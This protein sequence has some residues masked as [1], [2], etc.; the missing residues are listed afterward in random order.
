MRFLQE[1]IAKKRAQQAL[2]QA[3]EAGD[4]GEALRPGAAVDGPRADGGAGAP[5]PVG[6]ADWAMAD[7][8][9]AAADEDLFDDEAG[10]DWDMEAEELRAVA[11][12]TEAVGAGE[13]DEEEDYEAGDFGMAEDAAAGH[14]MDGDADED[15]D[16]DAMADDAMADD[17]MDDD[18]ED[19]TSQ[20]LRDIVERSRPEA[21]AW[22]AADDA[23]VV[24]AA[25]DEERALAAGDEIAREETAEDE[26]AEDETDA[27]DAWDE[28]AG[29][30]GSDEEDVA[31][32]GVV[33]LAA[34]TMLRSEPSL[35]ENI[36]K[37]R[38]QRKIWD[39]D[40]DDYEE[41]PEPAASA[42]P[43]RL[44]REARTD[45]PAEEPPAASAEPVPQ[46]AAAPEPAPAPAPAAAAPQQRRPGRVKTRLLGF[47]KGDE[48]VRDPFAATA[49]SAAGPAP[50]PAPAPKGEPQFPVGWMVVLEG[51]GRGAS[52]ALTAGASKIGR[53][54][55]QAIRLDFGDTSI[56]RDNHAAVA[57]DD[58]QRC[59]YIGHG[60]KANLVRL[61]DMPV[62]STEHLNDGDLIRIGET[63]LMFIALC[64]PEFS[65]EDDGDGDSRYAAAE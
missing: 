14:G 57:Y 51:P 12:A 13:A 22:A 39:M 53:G 2:G 27:D 15:P 49:T 44:D 21:V 7:D 5:A 62:L 42:S 38:V 52:F 9:P 8:D 16:A 34:P 30:D 35:E 37:L 41:D 65:W 58:E 32:T 23:F 4:D 40:G 47:H 11:E 33:P 6:H 50:T 60:G 59:F 1:M 3:P 43:L 54:E 26:S 63:T 20:V 10:Y 17:A 36:E 25:A 56:S 45:I 64:G 55:D 61:N 46:P 28:T 29:D 48:A 24:P 19:G 31:A 18:A